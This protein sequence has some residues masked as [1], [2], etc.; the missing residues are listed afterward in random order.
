MALPR[1]AGGR[2]EIVRAR[3]AHEYPVVACAL[4]HHSPYELL[5]STILSAQCTDDRVNT[6]T[7]ALF[8][9]Y[10]DVEAL[11]SADPDELARLIYSTGFYQAKTRNLIGMAQRVVAA[12][13]SEIPTAMEDLVTLPGVGRKT[14]NVVRSVAF[15]IPGLPV[16][17]HVGRLSRRLRLTDY[18]DPV[19]AELDL[20]RIIPAD[21][22][23][24]FS[25]RLI[26]HGRAVCD[27]RR[28]RCDACVLADVCPSAGQSKVST[29]ARASARRAPTKRRSTA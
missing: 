9:A 16:D 7:P 6:V 15:G 26:E 24:D 10:P 8:A 17:T 18:E 25:L 2:S 13:G 28:P 27:S 4:T 3:L 22:W 12:Y 11:T 5:V 1:G 19:A 14:A 23:G 20:M 21:E 29:S